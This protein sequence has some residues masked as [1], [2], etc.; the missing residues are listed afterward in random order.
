LLA[1]STIDEASI[2][3]CLPRWEARLLGCKKTWR[4]AWLDDTLELLS[5]Y[6]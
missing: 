2:H 1:G 6:G 3:G 4:R 5:V